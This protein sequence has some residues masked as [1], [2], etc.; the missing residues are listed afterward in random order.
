MRE[1]NTRHPIGAPPARVSAEHR[2]GADLLA[3][4]VEDN[5][6]ELPRIAQAAIEA[7]S[8]DR[9]QRLRRIAERDASRAR[10]LLGIFHCERKRAATGDARE[11]TGS[12]TEVARELGQEF[13][14]VA[15]YQFLA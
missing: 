14:V 5:L 11:A 2:V 6:R 7:L 8:R 1:R 4:H 9:M 13:D 12:R 3:R 10:R 15:R